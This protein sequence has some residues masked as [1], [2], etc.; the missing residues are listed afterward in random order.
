[1]SFPS[2][3]VFRS[4][5]VEGGGQQAS[6]GVYDISMHILSRYSS[7]YTF[8]SR[9]GK[10]RPEK[11]QELYKNFYYLIEFV[12]S[13][14]VCFIRLYTTNLDDVG[15]DLYIF[16]RMILPSHILF[17]PAENLARYASNRKVYYV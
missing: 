2:I 10:L 15:V 12:I 7:S 6:F 14:V 13:H 17:T 1:M 9:K 4:F 3:V 11:E 16:R 8:A 5:H